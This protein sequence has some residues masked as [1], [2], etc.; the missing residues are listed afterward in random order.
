MSHFA[1][2]FRRRDFLLTCGATLAAARFGVTSRSSAAERDASQLVIGKDR[3][4]IVQEA[5]P[6]SLET[7]TELL[8]SGETPIDLLF[9]R[10]N[11]S[12]PNS[13]TL[14]PV[15]LDGWTIELAGLVDKPVIIKASDLSAME[16]VEVT[17]VLQC[18]GNGRSL[19]SQAAMA[20]GSQWTRGGMGN[21]RFSGV[22][23]SAILEKYKVR[24]DPAARFVT[25]EGKDEALPNTDD[26]EHSLP[27]EDVLERTLLATK[28]NGKPLPA[29]HGGPVRF[30]TP[31]YYGTMQVKWLSRLRF[32]AAETA[33]H[34]HM[35]RYRVPKS[36]IKPGETFKPTFDNSTANWRMKTKSVVFAPQPGATVAANKPFDVRGVAF[37][38]GSARIESVLMSLDRGQTW[39]Q[40]QVTV[41][42]DAYA[43]Y[44]FSAA[45]TLPQGRHEIWV[46]A[47][48][49]LGRTQPLDGSIHWNPSGYEW[50]GSEKVTVTAV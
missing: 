49:A 22:P 35:P 17:M 31:G 44:G 12:L 28:L 43:W 36:P 37:N 20:K 27:L 14:Q 16:Q 46:R 2:T 45:A 39:R 6:V 1:Q 30:V 11:Q 50:N 5:A 34:H 41:P 19:F 15:P 23:L 7:P 4:L 48:D 8:N 40:T 42:K 3:R 47:V 9:V 18:S 13:D 26:F 24:I 32:E 33:N 29:V 10:N 25:A 21:V 38:D